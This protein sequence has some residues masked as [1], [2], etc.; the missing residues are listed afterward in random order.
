L[1]D[2]ALANVGSIERRSD[3]EKRLKILTPEELKD[4]V[5]EKVCSLFLS[6]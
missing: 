6:V 1:R 4:L 3:L 5:C 2:L